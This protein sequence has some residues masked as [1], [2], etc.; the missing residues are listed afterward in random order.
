MHRLPFLARRIR[1]DENGAT[2]V[3]FGLLITPLIVLLL[4]SLDMGMNIYLR[5]VLAGALEKASRSTTIEGAN[6]QE[7]AIDTVLTNTVKKVLPGATVTI[8][9]GRFYR[10][11]QLNA[12][13]RLTK[14]TNGN[15]TL[16]SGDCWEDIDNDSTRSTVSTGELN[17]I[18]GSDDIVRYA[19]TVTYPRFTPIYKLMGGS[20]TKSITSTMLV[21]RQPYANQGSPTVRC[22]P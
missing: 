10:Y 4:G 19:V 8:V 1:R 14:D 7:S 21:K 12:M 22:K 6:G 18:G 11:G 17:S 20:A 15:G 13:E 5:T 16:D 9:K 2:V 3:E